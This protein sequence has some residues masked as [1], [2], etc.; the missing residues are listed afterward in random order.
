MLKKL[1][2]NELPEEGYDPY[3][4]MVHYFSGKLEI[5]PVRCSESKHCKMSSF[6]DWT[7]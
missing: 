2:R 5:M 7:L 4:E 1:T 3:P 6:T